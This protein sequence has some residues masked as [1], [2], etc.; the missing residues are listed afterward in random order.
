[1]QLPTDLDAV[2]KSQ[3]YI[4]KLSYD[5]NYENESLQ[6]HCGKLMDATQEQWGT[7]SVLE[8][9]AAFSSVHNQEQAP[10]HWEINEDFL[11]WLQAKVLP[12]WNYW[13]YGPG[14]P[15]PVRSWVNVHK[16]SGRTQNI[17]TT[18]HHLLCLVISRYLKVQVLLSIVIPLEYHRWG[19]PGEPQIDLWN[20]VNVETNDILIFPG[21]L[22]HRTQVNRV[23]EDRVCMTINYALTDH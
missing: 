4:W 13:G 7:G 14:M 19:T 18:V 23:D 11:V 1:M 12:I 21:W 5:F 10:H 15:Q 17:I 2:A 6:E 16:R 8:T 22:K 3:T 20:E 9:G